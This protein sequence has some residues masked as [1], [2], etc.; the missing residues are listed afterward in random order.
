MERL[1]REELMFKY[2]AAICDLCVAYGYLQNL[3]PCSACEGR[4]CEQARVPSS[5][6]SIG[7]GPQP[8]VCVIENPALSP[9]L[10]ARNGPLCF[11]FC[12]L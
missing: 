9:I 2:D 1:T 6:Y 12:G 8:P 4:Y 3:A 10:L 7:L 5:L 11:V